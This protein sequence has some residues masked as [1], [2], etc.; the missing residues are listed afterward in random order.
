MPPCLQSVRA[1]L[2]IT[3]WTMLYHFGN[4]KSSAVQEQVLETCYG[5]IKE[6][7][8]EQEVNFLFP[9]PPLS[10]P[11]TL[12]SYPNLSHSLYVYLTPS[13][14]ISRSFT[15]FIFLSITLSPYLSIFLSICFDLIF[16]LLYTLPL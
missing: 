7:T 5:W 4:T 2:R 13:V 12:T 15:L 6:V 3:E 10:P 8:T 14:Y 11:L 9:F 16:F 1:L